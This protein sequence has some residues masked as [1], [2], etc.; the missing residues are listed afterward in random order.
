MF[1]SLAVINLAGLI[2]PGPSTFLLVPY[3]QQRRRLSAFW[4]VS[5]ILLSDLLLI[6]LTL[7]GA[8]RISSGSPISKL[9]EIAGGSIL[10]FFGIQTARGDGEDLLK[11]RKVPGQLSTL[12]I[13]R[14]FLVTILNPLYW[15]WWGTVGLSFLYRSRAHGLFGKLAFIAA[16]IVPT[17]SWFC[18]LYLGLEKG[19]G[20]ISPRTFRLI[21]LVCGIL[22]GLFG[23][24]LLVGCW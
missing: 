7:G 10:I 13:L 21:N 4:F 8:S 9:I 14:G 5:G 22:L 2:P 18:L 15:A 23:V 3:A 17:Y 24:W 12:S 19:V 16:I 6:L 11:E 1:V 20:M